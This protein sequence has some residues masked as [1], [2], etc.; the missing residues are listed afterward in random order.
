LYLLKA[1]S[2]LKGLVKSFNSVSIVEVS[3]TFYKR[4]HSSFYHPSSGY[5]T[6]FI[7][8]CLALIMMVFSAYSM[9]SFLNIGSY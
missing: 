2:M 1:L 8:I 4:S 7:L 6:K 3:I 5:S 9:S